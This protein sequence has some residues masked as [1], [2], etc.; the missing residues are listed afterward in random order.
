[1]TASGSITAAQIYTND[2]LRINNNNGGIY[3]QNIGRGIQSA[4][5]A[6]NYYGTISNYGSGRNGYNGY[7]F[8]SRYCMMKNNTDGTIGLYDI[9]YGWLFISTGN[10]LDMT[11]SQS[12]RCSQDWDRFMVYRNG[13]DTSGGYFYVN[14][15][16]G[17]GIASDERLK[18]NIETIPENKSIEF[19]KNLQPSSFCMKEQKECYRKNPDGKEELFTPSM[20]TCKEDGWIAQNVLESATRADIPKGVVNNWSDYQE[21]L[22]KPEEER[23]AILGVSDRPILSHTVN[24]VK[25][26]LNKVDILEKRNQ[27]LEEHARYMEDRLTNNE[28]QFTAYKLQNE[29]LTAV[30]EAQ[31]NKINELESIIVNHNN[32]LT[33]IF[34]RL[35]NKT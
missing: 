29:N 35:N 28:E 34:E 33:Q 14:Q 32:L 12:V 23:T 3:W 6:G 7:G 21:Q 1:M 2:F 24:V 22:D 13:Y 16:G 15:C 9:N 5:G 18:E 10:F 26:L 4:E 31:N 30:N 11:I 27:V 17:Y 25:H 19:I 8:D 20:C